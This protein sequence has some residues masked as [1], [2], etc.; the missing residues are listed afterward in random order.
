MEIEW[1]WTIAGL[2]GSVVFLMLL[3][4]PVVFA[5][6]SVNILG[7]I[8]FMGGD[9]GLMQLMRNAEESVQSFALLPIPL[10]I[11]MGEIMFYTGVASRAIDA[12]D[13]LIGAGAGASVFGRDHRRHDLLVPLRFDHRQHSHAQ[14]HPAAR[15]V[16]ARL[17][18]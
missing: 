7:A 2:I 17:Q 10:F 6:F 8:I 4:M 1:Y 12:I 16:Q 13:K 15:D 3:G 11:L 18:A 5:F 9:K 14:Q